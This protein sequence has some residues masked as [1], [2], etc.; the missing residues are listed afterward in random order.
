[1]YKGTAF[2]SWSISQSF[3]IIK[4]KIIDDDTK[5]VYIEINSNN[6]EINL[7]YFGKSANDTILDSNKQIVKDQS[8]EIKNLLVNDVKIEL[9][10]IKNCCKFV[11]EYTASRI[12][13][14]KDNNLELPTELNTNHLFDNGKWTFIFQRPFFLW[15]NSILMDLLNNSKTSIWIKRSNVGLPADDTLI[16]LDQL[17]NKL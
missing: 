14:A 8:L 2:P 17:L 9:L 13:Y 1:L 7:Q 12:K 16:R 11:P 5:V 10:S 3:K 6:S 15:Y 4:E